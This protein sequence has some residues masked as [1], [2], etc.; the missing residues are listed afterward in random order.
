M[1]YQY[2]MHV[3]T[4]M[5]LSQRDPCV[6]RPF[7]LSFKCHNRFAIL[8]QARIQSVIDSVTR[9]ARSCEW[10]KASDG[11]NAYISEIFG[12]NVFTLKKLQQ[13]LPK[14]VYA[15]FIQQIK[16]ALN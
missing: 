7:K 6:I 16:V 5:I 9:P 4:V 12:N 13:T 15:R 14:T 3:V 2:P 11:K 1:R 10:P 8:T